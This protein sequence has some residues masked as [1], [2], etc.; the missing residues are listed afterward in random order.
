MKSSIR[1][2]LVFVCCIFVGGHRIYSEY[3]LIKI[4]TLVWEPYVGPDL[5][6]GGIVTEITQR[7]FDLA[8]Y[9]STV[10]YLPWQQAQEDA[11]DGKYDAILPAYYSEERAQLYWI[12]EPVL[13]SPVVLCARTGTVT[14]FWLL[15]DLKPYKIGIARGYVNATEFDQAD[16]LNK[17]V[18]ETDYE[19]MKDLINGK[20]DLVCIDKMV[21]SHM[22]K[23]NSEILGAMD[24]YIFLTPRLEMRDIYVMFPRVIETSKS[25]MKAFNQALRKMRDSGEID[26][27]L[28]KHGFK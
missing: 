24:D 1:Y 21:C 26:Q 6:G 7:A 4:S 12:S 16:Y 11:L 10:D 27:I 2:L 3:S 8:G 15:S 25:R 9:D 20:L 18:G 19:N 28:E 5:P 22:I 13:A 14:S 17:I 23:S